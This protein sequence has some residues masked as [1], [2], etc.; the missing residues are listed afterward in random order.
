MVKHG[1]LV[2]A[3]DPAEV[4]QEATATGHHLRKSNFLKT[5]KNYFPFTSVSM[6]ESDLC[7]RKTVLN[8]QYLCNINRK[9]P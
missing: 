9:V 5:E 7:P 3:A 4:A 2:L 8:I 6:T 1:A